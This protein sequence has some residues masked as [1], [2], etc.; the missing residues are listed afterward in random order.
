MTN[1]LSAWVGERRVGSF[2]NVAGD[3]NVF[4]F[5]EEYLDDPAPP[6]LSQ[7]FITVG[8]DT[9]RIVPRTRR[10]APPFFAN[11][12]PEPD[13]T[14]RGIIARRYGIN[15]TR[16]FP[17]LEVLGHDLP[18]AVVLRDSGG[19]RFTGADAP[20]SGG[21]MPL[22]R[23]LR[24]SLAGVQLKFSA[25][26]VGQRLTIPVDGIGGSW[27]A[28]LPT[29]AFPRLP[30][31]EYAVMSLAKAV[32]LIVPR[33]EMFDLDAMEGLPRDL[34]AL[35]ADEPRRVYAIE[36][37][38]RV[39][40]GGRVHVEDFNQV[41]NQAPADKY[42]NKATQW[43]ANV[44]D[45]LCPDDDVEEF[46]RRLV[47]GICT[48]N[49]DM[50]LKNWALI[51]P[52]GRNA[53]IAPMYD[54]VCTRMYYPNGSLALTIGGERDFERID[55]DALRAFAK[56]AQLAPKRTLAVAAETVGALRETWPSFKETISDRELVAAVE[57]QFAAVPLMA[58][59]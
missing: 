32:G 42:D 31:N 34:P 8:G 13:T 5:D 57:R 19:A 15:R 33:I 18:G 49:N 55:R 3:L 44:I 6:V 11:L 58:G 17:F 45:V 29:N 30:Q 52:D 54:F 28:K 22:E 46:V 56:R 59:R 14:L 21:S 48:G 16:D 51:Y 1:T 2:S 40:G 10:V 53:R 25:S 36:R 50:H 26:I 37:F 7:S 27:I 47:F 12:L 20:P 4:H 35:R 41:A 39:P 24:F 38:D 9:V 43:I 23:P